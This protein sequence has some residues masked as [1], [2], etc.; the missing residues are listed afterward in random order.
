MDGTTYNIKEAHS[1]IEIVY[2]FMKT[3][4]LVPPAMVFYSV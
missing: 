1:R 3:L 4:D 2:K